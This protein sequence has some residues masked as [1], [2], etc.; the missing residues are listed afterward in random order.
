MMAAM[1]LAAALA[2]CATQQ[3]PTYVVPVPT[4]AADA[5]ADAPAVEDA[6][7]EAGEV[8]AEGEATEIPVLPAVTLT[9]LPT[10]P[11][12]ATATFEPPTEVPAPTATVAQ[13]PPAEEPV[14]VVEEGIGGGAVE[15]EPLAVLMPENEG[16]FVLVDPRGREE[17]RLIGATG[18]TRWGLI[19]TTER[20]VF[21]YDE[22]QKVIHRIDVAQSTELI[23]DVVPL[24]D[25]GFFNGQFLPSPDGA[26]LAIGYTQTNAE[27]I[28]DSVSVLQVCDMAGVC[29]EVVREARSEGPRVP[30]PVGWTPD[31]GAVY[32]T[33]QQYGIGGYIL[34]WGGPDLVRAEIETGAQTTIV[35][36]R[37]CLCAMA[38][39]PDGKRLAWIDSSGPSLALHVSDLTTGADTVTALPVEIGQAGAIAWRPDS[40]AFMYTEAIGDYENEAY[41]VAIVDVTT[42]QR[43]YLTR[44]DLLLRRSANW[45]TVTLAGL[46]DDTG[47]NAWLV[48]VGNLNEA[49]P[50][51]VSAGQPWGAFR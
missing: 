23:L 27:N 32:Y 49:I 20:Y 43:V 48:D 42:G 45:F 4:T 5:V 13:A 28:N 1:L 37:P 18:L 9:P 35:R 34:F 40:G 3:P 29:R 39:S 38:I 7:P 31:N 41:S 44:N 16:S 2:G 21:Y 26:L 19:A 50:A 36:E 51:Q 33:N 22:T 24:D 15:R 25:F 30:T 6:A 8:A 12:E 10:L 14:P 11:A 46:N 17:D 47:F